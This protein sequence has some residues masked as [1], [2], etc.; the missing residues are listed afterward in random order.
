VR[1][2]A[3]SRGLGAKSHPLSKLPRAGWP[4]DYF[5]CGHDVDGLTRFSEEA[6][7]VDMEIAWVLLAEQLLINLMEFV[8]GGFGGCDGFT[9]QGKNRTL[10]ARS[11]FDSRFSRS[12]TETAT[13]YIERIKV[14]VPLIFL[15][16]YGTPSWL[17]THI[18]T[19]IQTQK[20]GCY[21]VCNSVDL[22]FCD[23]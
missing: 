5:C 16:R 15:Q 9:Y 10:R 19:F 22:G 12:C 3:V 20:D 21:V 7:D 11:D 23:G 14:I 13:R 6:R 18:V 17:H 1:H 2:N 4:V 8:D